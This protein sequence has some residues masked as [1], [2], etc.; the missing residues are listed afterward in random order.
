MKRLHRVLEKG[1]DGTAQLWPEV[2]VGFGWLH[3]AATV[4]GNAAGEVTLE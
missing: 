4:L 2:E 3:R 1:L